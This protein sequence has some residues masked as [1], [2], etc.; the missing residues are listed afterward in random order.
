MMVWNS[1][2]SP[3][4]DGQQVLALTKPERELVLVSFSNEIHMGN[5]YGNYFIGWMPTDEMMEAEEGY[6]PKFGDDKRCL[7]GHTYVRHFDPYEEWA[8]VGCKYCHNWDGDIKYRKELATTDYEEVYPTL[9]S[10]EQTAYWRSHSSICDGFKLDPNPNNTG[11]H[12]C[13]QIEGRKECLCPP[14][15]VPVDTST[16]HP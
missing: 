5:S 1:F 3:P 9:S 12:H 15:P 2:N 10:E 7:C 6:D 11:C 4:K 8:P 13:D 16:Q 14:K